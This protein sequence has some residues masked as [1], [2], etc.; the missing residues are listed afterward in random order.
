MDTLRASLAIFRKDLLAE[1]RTK[2]VSIAILLFGFTV[3]V[4]F[5]FAFDPTSD[6]ARRIAGGL[7]WLAFLFASLLGLNR[8][9]AR[10][11]ANDCLQGLRLMPVDLGSIYLGKLL[12]NLLFMLAAELVLLPVFNIFFNL[13]LFERPGWLALILLLGTWG[14]ASLGTIFSAV[15]ANTRMRELMLPMLL[16]PL[17][18]PVLIAA[19]ESTTILLRGLPMR[20]AELWIKLL[21]GFDVIFTVLAWL[22]FDSVVQE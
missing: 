17:T 20:E 13:N 7:L 21:A 12:S 14:V 18:I 6:E 11:T 19:I 2:D 8:S 4:A 1:R 5:A 16:L 9:F 15:S 3:A 22:L 10:E